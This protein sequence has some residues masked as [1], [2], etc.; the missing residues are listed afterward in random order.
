MKS[1]LKYTII[2]TI[3]ACLILGFL[4]R[5]SVFSKDDGVN[6]NKL[7]K[8]LEDKEVTFYGVKGNP[9]VQAQLNI[10]GNFSEQIEFIDCSK[11]PEECQGIIFYPTWKIEGKIY[12]GGISL[13]IL[14][15][16]L[17]C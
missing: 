2:L 12:Q 15:T 3:L 10:L 6:E 8:C 16:F 7:S 9:A 17:N 5:D 4:F 14:E 1:S 11:T 13:G